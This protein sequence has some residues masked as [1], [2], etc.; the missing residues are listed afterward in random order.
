MKRFHV[1]VSV[2][3]LQDSLRFYSA[4]F[5]VEPVVLRD[6]YAK[7]VLED[8]RINFAISRRGHQPG[9]N[10]L[11]IQADN[12]Q[13]LQEIR[14]RLER[15]RA[16]GV[17]AEQTA[18]DGTHAEQKAVACCYSKSDKYW[19]VDPQDIAW[20]AFHTIG[21][22][23]LYG[24]DAAISETQISCCVP[25]HDNPADVGKVGSCCVPAEKADP[26]K[27]GKACCA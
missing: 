14:A 4:I 21:T 24:E 27:H 8:P 13:E 10:H 26:D 3:R 16:D 5:G 9:L 15:A 19:V 22:I 7:W 23:P 12:D 17:H 11:G 18:A 20:E 1:H 2:E 25:L 6:D